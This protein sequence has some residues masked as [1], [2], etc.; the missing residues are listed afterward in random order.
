MST[1]RLDKDAESS[2]VSE[3]LHKLDVLL[4]DQSSPL[5]STLRSCGKYVN[6]KLPETLDAYRST[7]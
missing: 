3:E 1:T 5:M 2:D 6:E 7:V 4:K